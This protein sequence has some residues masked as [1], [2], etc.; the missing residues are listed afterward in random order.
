[1]AEEAGGDEG[2]AEEAG[3]TSYINPACPRR[4]V[5]RSQHILCKHPPGWRHGE[6]AMNLNRRSYATRA[7]GRRDPQPIGHESVVRCVPVLDQS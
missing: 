1:M 4:W 2:G 5:G 6:V 3:D 7:I